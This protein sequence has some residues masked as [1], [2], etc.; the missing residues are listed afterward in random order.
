MTRKRMVLPVVCLMVF[1]LLFIQT[2]C[3]DRA[4]AAERMADQANQIPV[5]MYHGILTKE[6][7]QL[8]PDNS[9]II[10]VDRFQEQMQFLAEN[11]YHTVTVDEME[12]FLAGDIQLPRKSVM[13]QF[14]DGLRSVYRYAYPMMKQ[15]NLNG[16][17]NIITGRTYMDY[18][19]E[20]D[21]A[22]NQYMD[23]DMLDKVSEVF[24][25]QSHT[26]QLHF[27]RSEQGTTDFVLKSDED[28]L[29]DLR[30]NKDRLSKYGDVTLFAYPFG[31]YNSN[32]KNLLK[33][34]GMTM[35]FTTERGYVKAWDDPYELKRIG[36]N[37]STTL[38]EFKGIVLNTVAPIFEDI[39]L[40]YPNFEQTFWLYTNYMTRGYPDGLFRPKQHINRVQAARMLMDMV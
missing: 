25:L 22:R 32:A 37:P 11:G 21:P 12:A 8:Q 34:A 9:N 4:N 10:T 14:D 1:I 23:E 16:V 26:N 17:A 24:D 33:K 28:V 36:I 20:W 19:D 39:S 18:G 6:E 15:L 38:E 29:S 2:A 27:Y 31:D 3:S 7:K 30:L 40:S 5:L 35:A 13:I